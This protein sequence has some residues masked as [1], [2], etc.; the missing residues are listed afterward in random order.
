MA[1]TI[2]ELFLRGNDLMNIDQLPNEEVLKRAVERHDIDS[3]IFQ[4]R[5][6][7]FQQGKYTDEF[8]YGRYQLFEE[9]DG[10]LRQLSAGARVLDLG[11]G[12]GHFADYIRRRGHEV[13]GLDPSVKM[14]ALARQ[15]FPDIEFIE[16][17]SNNLPFE[18]HHFDCVISIEVLRYLNDSEVL[19]SYQEIKRTLRPGG[20]LLVTH[21][22][23]LA[24][25]GY[26]V[27]YQLKRLLAGGLGKT[28]HNAYFTSASKEE[29]LL[30]ETGFSSIEC[31]GRMSASVRVG[32][33]FGKAIG[34]AWAR[35]LELVDPEQRSVNGFYRDLR[36][37]LVVVAHKP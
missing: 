15:N 6:V 8:I 13:V 32:Y 28:I 7:N 12:T 24:T 23:T 36:G 9:I 1:P 31:I 22:N 14:L 26:F 11:C 3:S 25:E 30:R 18:A 4:G 2:V 19:R 17:Y 29:R 5:Y 37:H 20:I 27:Y 16:G 10:V 35:A 34:T 21:V 33:K